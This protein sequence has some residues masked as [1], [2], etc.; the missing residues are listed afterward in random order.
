MAEA[1]HARLGAGAVGVCAAS[2]QAVAVGA[3]TTLAALAIQGAHTVDVDDGLA[4][5]G[6]VHAHFTHRALVV[7]LALG[8]GAEARQAGLA[9]GALAV[10][11]AR[12]RGGLGFGGLASAI[13]ALVTEGAFAAAGA[14][15]DVVDARAV[16]AD[17]VDRA[18]A[19]G[20][21]GRVHLIDARAVDADLVGGALAA[22]QAAWLHILDARAVDA[23]LEI[24]RAHV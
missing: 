12:L 9:C 3:L 7:G 15:H 18:L 20:L 17:L 8:D 22:V 2:K 6:A 21:A 24:G 10:V 5:A 19:V 1:V 13:D 4:G 14:G 16:H 11:L 23:V